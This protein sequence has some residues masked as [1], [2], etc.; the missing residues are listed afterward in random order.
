[1]DEVWIAEPGGAICEGA[2]LST[3]AR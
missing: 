2:N 1:M 3:M